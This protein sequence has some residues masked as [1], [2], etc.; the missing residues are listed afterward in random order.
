MYKLQHEVDELNNYLKTSGMNDDVF[1]N[2]LKRVVQK[3]CL[4]FKSIDFETF[5]E[6]NMIKFQQQ[7]MRAIYMQNYVRAAHSWGKELAIIQLREEQKIAKAENCFI[8]NGKILLFL[9]SKE[10]VDAKAVSK[11]EAEF[12]L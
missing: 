2:K 4:Q 9:F 12:A 5:F 3:N 11:L 7:K 10:L 1:F 6:N 8:L